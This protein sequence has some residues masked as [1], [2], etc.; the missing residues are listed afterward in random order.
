M[1]EHRWSGWPGAW[2]QDCG[3]EDARELC[4]AGHHREKAYQEILEGEEKMML[5]DHVCFNDPCPTTTG[6]EA[7]DA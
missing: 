2:C 4:L 1:P 6:R 5:G 3:A 7:A